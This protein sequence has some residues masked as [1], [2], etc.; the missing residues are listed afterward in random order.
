MWIYVQI[1]HAKL[2]R[3]GLLGNRNIQYIPLYVFRCI[4]W[5]N[6]RYEKVILA[7]KTNCV[8]V[9][10]E[11]NRS[12]NKIKTKFHFT[13]MCVCVWLYCTY[14]MYLAGNHLC[15]LLYLFDFKFES[16]HKT[17]NEN[18]MKWIN[19]M[20]DAEVNKM[21]KCIAIWRAQW[22]LREYTNRCLAVWEQLK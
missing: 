18:E 3:T 8:N 21:F 1:T 5:G 11:E 20:C 7:L 12:N 6:S 2:L 15:F 17:R 16:T 19:W 9:F 10:S 22:G 4:W 13:D 14:C